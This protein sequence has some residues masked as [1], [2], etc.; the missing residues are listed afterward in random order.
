MATLII[1]NFDGV[2]LGH[3]GLIGCAREISPASEVVAVTFDTHPATLTRNDAPPRLTSNAER[4]KLLIAA[5]VSRVESLETTEALL[6]LT[7]EEFVAFLKT[8]FS[9]TTV[10]EG[11]DF[12][13][14]R[15][16]RGDVNTLRAIGERE[17][18]RT[19]VA[20]EVDV[21]LQDGTLVSARSS[22]VR[23]LLAQ[24]RVAD[25]SRVLGRPHR[26]T[27]RVVAGQRRGRELGYPTANVAHC[28]VVLPADGIYAVGVE[29]A[30][31]RLFKGA[32]SLGSN[33]TFG[34]CPRTLEVHILQMPHD[35]DMYGQPISI[36]FHRWLR[37]MMRFDS[38]EVLIA[39]IARD[40]AQVVA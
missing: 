32:A 2:H 8:K 24:G 16:R 5:G 7:P 9:I 34:D 38:T 3:Q 27:G 18:F 23:W 4:E 15:G 37:G 20:K 31:G 1:G 17:K 12:R 13:F 22:M 11:A 28:D 25:A 26:V 30:Q 14:G 40:C 36:F 10:V 35:S 33:P 29:D 6:R 39:Q 19:V 21:A